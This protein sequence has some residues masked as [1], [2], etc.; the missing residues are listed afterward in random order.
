MSASI[1][2]VAAA[3]GVSKSTASLA[4]RNHPSV[5]EETRL[6][7]QE[8]AAKLQ[9]RVNPLVSAL[10]T[11]QRAGH[12]AEG[13]PVIALIDLYGAPFDHHPRR[14]AVKMPYGSNLHLEMGH[15][16]AHAAAKTF[17][18]A[19]DVITARTAGMTPDRLR[20]IVSARGIRG[21]LLMM[22][23]VPEVT[24]DWMLDWTGVSVVHLGSPSSPFHHVRPNIIGSV[25]LLLA[26]LAR[27]GYRRP[28]LLIPAS[29]ENY[30]GHRWQM[31]FRQHL[32]SVQG[33]QDFTF[34]PDPHGDFPAL[35]RW[36]KQEHPDVIACMGSGELPVLIREGFR[37]PED[38]GYVG[39]HLLPNDIG[40]VAGLD[41][42]YDARYHAAVQLLDSLLRHNET[43]IPETP[44]AV[45][46]T[47][48]WIDGPTVRAVS[49]L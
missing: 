35:L 45:T 1:R 20:S 37:V 36:M 42:R 33:V 41:L 2:S 17:G 7:V 15:S 40:K 9:Y 18:Y 43:G 22:P 16:A 14:P 19:L 28:G 10:M 11:Q 5:A 12:A 4:L 39:L 32:A 38:I 25:Q 31:A 24:Q 46:I 30:A 6:R 44:L 47:G 21:I 23:P 29:N 13:T 49:P 48:R 34:M 26:E 3:A 27:R 8:A